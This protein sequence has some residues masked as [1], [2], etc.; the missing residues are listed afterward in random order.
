MIKRKVQ[1][2]TVAIV[3]LMAILA[4]TILHNAFSW[5]RSFYS[6]QLYSNALELRT[7]FIQ[8]TVRNL[9]TDIA[10]ER[11]GQKEEFSVRLENSKAYVS[12][13]MTYTDK[14]PEIV[15][16]EYL[17]ERADA[18]NWTYLAY[19]KE[20]NEIIMDSD[21]LLGDSFDG[22]IKEI[23]SCFAVSE[24]I[25][26][27]NTVVLYGV[28]NEFLKRF[29][30]SD[31]SRKV[32]YDEFD[33]DTTIWINEIRNF[34]G[35]HNY[36]LHIS[37][38]GGLIKSGR[39]LT[40]DVTDAVGN[41]YLSTELEMIKETGE[42]FYTYQTKKDGAD[43][44]FPTLV[45]AKLLKDYNWVIG[46]QSDMKDV[47]LTVEETKKTVNRYL[48]LLETGLIIAFLGLIIVVA[49]T[50]VRTERAF[51][52]HETRIL[53]RKVQN[54]ALTGATSR[55]FG[56]EKLKEFFQAFKD[57]KP[58]PVIMILD[59]DY[60]KQIND[61]YGHD[62]GDVVLKRVV[63]G[64]YRTIR[65]SDYLIRW[66]GDEFIGVYLGVTHENI[67]IVAE[68]VMESVRLVRV[69]TEDG[70]EIKVTSSVGFAEFAD[71]DD[72]YGDGLKRA[73]NML[74]ESKLGGRN[75]YHIASKNA[76]IDKDKRS[77][78]ISRN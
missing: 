8:N 21:G 73:D 69:V 41:E 28:T 32:E 25:E 70:I 45:Y 9:I 4:M 76:V 34:E 26:F 36:A 50:T 46:M 48:Y 49:Y 44:I 38:S 22:N 77:D 31:I 23:E 61:T 15:I 30:E 24:K 3:T 71:S 40:T 57:G 43:E 10:A 51:T 59:V 58:S 27:E 11:E 35:G 74:Y 7:E 63:T 55:Q 13:L 60:F 1:K 64:L 20:T 67:E 33:G 56:E 54:D 65:Q 5:I 47:Y 72:E 19:D 62:V 12:N 53:R 37:D 14:K 29:V 2:K 42:A 39:L 78:S 75:Q 17:R 16:R 66:G 18:S 6:E 52:K 68:K